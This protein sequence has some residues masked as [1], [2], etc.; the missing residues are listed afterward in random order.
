ME[1]N[2]ND[3]ILQCKAEEEK[4]RFNSFSY[5]DAW[6]LGNIMV[7]I[8]KEKS[9]AITIQ[10]MYKEQIMFHA[11]INGPLPRTANWIRRKTNTVMYANKSSLHFCA[12]LKQ[13]GKKVA[14]LG[15]DFDDYVECG[16]G[17]PIIV[18]GEGVVGA[19]AVSGLFHTDDHQVMV[20]ALT[21]YLDV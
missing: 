15:L 5:D 1:E 21:E 11:A 6:D 12:L 18:K 2:F 14:D 16:G 10:I 13:D 9:Y 20:D 8:A 7:K 19:I 3:L 4:L 17:F